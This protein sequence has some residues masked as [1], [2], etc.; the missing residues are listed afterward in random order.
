[1][2]MPA[3]DT[4]DWGPTPDIHRNTERDRIAVMVSPMVRSFKAGISENVEPHRF[5]GSTEL[6]PQKP[7]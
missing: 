3:Q 2:V 4:I 1:M 7:A 6:T 5:P